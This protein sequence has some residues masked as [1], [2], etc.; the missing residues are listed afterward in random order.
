MAQ[1]AGTAA[2]EDE[3]GR[4]HSPVQSSAP[5]NAVISIDFDVDSSGRAMRRDLYLL[6]RIGSNLYSTVW[7]VRIDLSSRSVLGATGWNYDREPGSFLPSFAGLR[8]GNTIMVAIDAETAVIGEGEMPLG[9]G[10]RMLG[11][12]YEG[13]RMTRPHSSYAHYSG[14]RDYRFQAAEASPEHYFDWP[15][16]DGGDRG[17]ENE[18]RRR[19]LLFCSPREILVTKCE[20]VS[21]DGR[22]EET[23]AFTD[24]EELPAT[25]IKRR[26]QQFM[27]RR[28]RELIPRVREKG[29]CIFL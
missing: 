3:D 2:A 4:R 17:K 19:L 27:E 22:K 9:N 21:E 13:R 6:K 18:N 8:R 7:K 15:A 26:L 28:R 10:R 12:T 1:I 14:I 25:D 23:W 20:L 29:R 24:R 5:S 11:V 16:E